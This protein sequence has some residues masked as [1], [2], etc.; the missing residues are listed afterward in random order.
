MGSTKSRNNK[1][2]KPERA[3]REAIVVVAAIICLHQQPPPGWSIMVDV[4]PPPFINYQRSRW[5]KERACLLMQPS[6]KNG[7]Y[8][9]F[10][11]ND[12][13]FSETSRGFEYLK[14]ENNDYSARKFGKYWRLCQKVLDVE[15]SKLS[16]ISTWVFKYGE[17]Q[18]MSLFSTQ[19]LKN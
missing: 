12:R 4:A 5:W 2:I 9:K 1:N 14:L 19:E 3:G 15:Y 10:K 16:N 13:S 6:S 11:A 7:E 8:L 18:N 17:F